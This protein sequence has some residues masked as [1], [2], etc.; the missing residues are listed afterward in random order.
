[1]EP[2]LMFQ[3][4]FRKPSI[5]D[6]FRSSEDVPA[7]VEQAIR[8][9]K[10]HGKLEVIWMQLG[11]IN[12]QAA[13]KARNA[14]LAVVMDKCMM[15]EHKRLRARDEDGSTE[16]ARIITDGTSNLGESNAQSWTASNADTGIDTLRIWIEGAST[17]GAVTA[18]LGMKTLD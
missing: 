8:L 4:R 2:C 11:I 16:L 10:L 17:V 9:K 1:M 14:G 18:N 3:L 13:E 5:V 6:V 15:R 12:E 7:I